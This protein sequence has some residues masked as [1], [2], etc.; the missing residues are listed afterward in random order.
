MALVSLVSSIPCSVDWPVSC[1]LQSAVEYLSAA[2]LQPQTI[3]SRLSKKLGGRL[4][5]NKDSYV[6]IG[7]D[8]VTLNIIK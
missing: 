7:N 8:R 3:V 2:G 1:P 6:K 4:S 5:H